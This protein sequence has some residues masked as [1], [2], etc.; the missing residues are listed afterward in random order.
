M[1]I[2]HELQTGH[3]IVEPESAFEVSYLQ[4]FPHATTVR[5][6]DRRVRMIALYLW[7]DDGTV[8]DVGDLHLTTEPP[9]SW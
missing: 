2:R 5:R 8:D 1:K 9:E 4:E 6:G 3:L 7:T